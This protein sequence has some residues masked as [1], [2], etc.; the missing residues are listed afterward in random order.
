MS[1]RKNDILNE[2]LSIKPGEHNIIVYEDLLDFGK[3]YSEY[4]KHLL[5]KK[6]HA[7]FLIVFTEDKDTV[8]ENLEHAGINTARRLRDGSLL[9]EEA[10][11]DL[12]CSQDAMLHHFSRLKE[13]P[14]NTGKDGLVI[15]LDINC[16][17]LF[18]N[19]EEEKLLDFESSVLVKNNIFLENSSLLC[20]YPLAIMGKLKENRDKINS[21][22]H[23]VIHTMVN[24]L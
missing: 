4:C 21:Y 1:S 2:L 6:N 18:G 14:K 22:H 15:L 19:D 16:L 9:I 7:V 3:I 17:Y 5:E 8:I 12:F 11:H 24:Q 10:A 13:Y 20:C 23:K